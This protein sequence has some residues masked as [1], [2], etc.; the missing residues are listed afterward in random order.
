MVKCEFLTVKGT[1]GNGMDTKRKLTA[2]VI[3]ITIALGYWWTR[4]PVYSVK[5]IQSHYPQQNG[6]SQTTVIVYLSG[7]S[8]HVKE[9][10][11]HFP[12]D[13]ILQSSPE[14]GWTG[15][16]KVKVGGVAERYFMG[17]VGYY[18]WKVE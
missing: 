6:N 5:T 16:K 4:D 7:E 15:L 14:T 11:C 10:L 3:L 18:C 8:G 9:I 17:V 12:P 2:I 1:E 13:V